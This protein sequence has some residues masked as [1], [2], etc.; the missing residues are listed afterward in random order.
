MCRALSP[1]LSPHL[2]RR[3]ADAGIEPTRMS[4]EQRD[5]SGF[6]LGEGA[7]FFVLEEREHEQARGAKIYVSG[8]SV[9]QI[10]HRGRVRLATE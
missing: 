5:R 6:V 2:A 4:R 7:W 1:S 3:V 9:E 8:L 10:L